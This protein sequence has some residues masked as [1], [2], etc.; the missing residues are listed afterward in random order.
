MQKM[1]QN[2]GANQSKDV[3]NNKTVMAANEKKVGI[4]F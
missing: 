1:N 3:K 4:V 2:K